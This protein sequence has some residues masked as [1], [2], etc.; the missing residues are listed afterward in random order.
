VP[1]LKPSPSSPQ[2]SAAAWLHSRLEHGETIDIRGD[3]K[4]GGGLVLVIQAFGS[5]VS[6]R[7]GLDVQNWPLFSS[8]RK[9]ANVRAFLRVGRGRIE[10][11][12][13]VTRPDVAVLMNEAAAEVIDFAE[14]TENGLFVLNTKK[15]PEE[16]AARYRLG[17]TVATV[18]GDALG[19]KHLSR[20]L[21]NVAVF[22][23]LVRLTELVDRQLARTSL[24]HALQKRRLPARVV[25]SNLLLFDEAFE[26]VR[27]ASVPSDEKTRHP[28]RL[29]TGYK[30]MPVAGQAALRS[31]RRNCTAGYGRPGVKMEFEDLQAKCNGCS[32]CVV[33]CPEGIIEFK[34]DPARGAMVFGARFDDYCKGCRECITACPLDLFREVEAVTLPE[35]RLAGN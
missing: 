31:S 6:L 24:E 25:S 13:Q 16:A 8:A 20:P 3:G 34:A 15:A 7:D 23:A 11:A 19:L 1:D 17:G 18:S 35:G 4:A 12:C 22:A 32:L 29:F 21:G 9:G 2:A 10:M 26:Q 27:M 33:Q 14:G 5:A 30:G 28:R